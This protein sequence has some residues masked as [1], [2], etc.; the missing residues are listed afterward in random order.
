MAV[1]AEVPEVAGFHRICTELAGEILTQPAA[2]AVAHA[3]RAALGAQAALIA[4]LQ[5]QVDDYRGATVFMAPDAV[6]D[7]TA[8]LDA[9]Y[10][11]QV[12]L[13]DI[14]RG[15]GTGRE[16]CYQG[17]GHWVEHP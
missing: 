8:A 7:D 4:D 11:A 5:Q 16:M 1:M 6:L 14:V 13:G 9:A 10:G 15:T 3:A 12:Q 17:P 2:H